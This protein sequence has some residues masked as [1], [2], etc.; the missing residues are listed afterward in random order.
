MHPSGEADVE[1][2]QTDIELGRMGTP[3]ENQL[4]HQGGSNVEGHPVFD[5]PTM[6]INGSVFALAPIPSP[7]ALPPVRFDSKL[8]S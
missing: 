2:E 5:L 1:N 8:V 4:V 7:P 3:V 6:H